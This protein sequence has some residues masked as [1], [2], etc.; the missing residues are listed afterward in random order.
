MAES[1]VEEFIANVR[2]YLADKVS[3]QGMDQDAAGFRDAIRAK[4]GAKEMN[5]DILLGVILGFTEVI[6]AANSGV[7][8]GCACKNCVIRLMFTQTLAA[9]IT[10]QSAAVL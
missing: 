7:L 9:D 10:R 1:P 2:N 6:E 5:D 3:P 4:L 8:D